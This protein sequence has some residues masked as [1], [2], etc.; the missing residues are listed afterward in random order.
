MLGAADD[1]PLYLGKTIVSLRQRMASY[2]NPGPTQRTNIR[3]K[4]RIRDELRAGRRIAV[5]ALWPGDLEWRGLPIDLAAGM[6]AALIRDM[7]PLW[8]D[9]R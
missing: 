6:E 5:Y 1:E 7:R 2:R 3:L 4:E 9:R 8:N